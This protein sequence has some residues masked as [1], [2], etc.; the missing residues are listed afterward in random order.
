VLDIG[1]GIGRIGRAVAAEF[2]AI[3]AI[4]VSPGMLTEARRRCRDLANVVFACCSGCDLAFVAAG[5]IDLVLAVDSFPYL[6]AADPTLAADHMAEAAHV[7]RPGGSLLILN[8][9]YGGDLAADRREVTRL[10]AVHGLR[11]Q[12]ATTRDFMLSDGATFLLRK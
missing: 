3:I 9:S 6:V 10:A 12:R 5:A 8:Y 7:L 11:L 4:D 2:A 1:C